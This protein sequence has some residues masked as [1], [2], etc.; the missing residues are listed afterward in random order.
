ME[1]LLLIFKALYGVVV[2]T[3]LL[4]SMF[5]VYHIVRYSYSRVGTIVMLALFLAVGGALLFSNAV[6]FAQLPLEDL[7]ESL[8]P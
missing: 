6:L 2:T 8:I 1:M 4:M 7:L 3:V 5:I